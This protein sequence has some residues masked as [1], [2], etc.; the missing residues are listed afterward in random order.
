MYPKVE[1]K[2]DARLRGKRLEKKSK[3]CGNAQISKFIYNILYKT[4][5]VQTQDLV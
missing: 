4:N 5:R 1:M 3:I 2:I